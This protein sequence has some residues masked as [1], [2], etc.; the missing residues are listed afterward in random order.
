M[1]TVVRDPG[2]HVGLRA[3]ARAHNVHHPS[4]IEAVAET[5]EYGRGYKLACARS[6][7]PCLGM[8]SPGAGG[9]GG[10]IRT[11]RGR[12]FKGSITALITPFKNGLL[13]EEAL[14]RLVE[15]Q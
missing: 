2:R 13:D 9:C 8:Y 15:W 3:A 6:R 1:K 11:R 5:S 10:N 7:C 4:R 14:G 12:M